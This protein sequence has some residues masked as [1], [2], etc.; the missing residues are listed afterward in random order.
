[1]I[2]YHLMPLP[3]ET[4]TAHQQLALESKD[5]SF[6]CCFASPFPRP[7]DV[8]P[9]PPPEGVW[10]KVMRAAAGDCGPFAGLQFERPLKLGPPGGG[11]SDPWPPPVRTCS[12]RLETAVE[13]PP[14]A[15]RG[16][17]G[18]TDWHREVGWGGGGLGFGLFLPVR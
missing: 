14:A 10:P 17:W 11:C 7:L 18:G 16:S 4:L 3:G 2:P 15:N 13:G 1:M 9:A 12:C 8:T 6:F 5:A